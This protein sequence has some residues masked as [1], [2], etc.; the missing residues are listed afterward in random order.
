M[1]FKNKGMRFTFEGKNNIFSMSKIELYENGRFD[2]D[3][4][5]IPIKL[6]DG[7]FVRVDE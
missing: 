5:N 6:P 3:G 7:R 4:G 1:Q 2:S